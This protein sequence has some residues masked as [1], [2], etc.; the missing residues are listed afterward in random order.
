MPDMSSLLKL[1]D[2]LAGLSGGVAI[3]LLVFGV[4][5]SNTRMLLSVACL[6]VVAIA[7]PLAGHSLVRDVIPVV[8]TQLGTLNSVDLHEASGLFGGP[9]TST[10][11]TSQ[12]IYQVSGAVSAKLGASVSS[13]KEGD[14]SLQ[15]CIDGSCYDAR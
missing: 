8:T 2:V 15:I 12:G 3:A 11:K 4:V 13:N 5:T 10:V 6:A 14:G 1:I 7:A 9:T